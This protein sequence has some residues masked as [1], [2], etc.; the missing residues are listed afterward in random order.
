LANPQSLQNFHP[1]YWR[2]FIKLFPILQAFLLPFVNFF[3]FS[4]KKR[5]SLSFSLFPLRYH[6]RKTRKG[7]RFMKIAV[8][9]GASS[10]MGAEFA[11]HVAKKESFDA[12]WLIA[13][14]ADR[15]EA[16]AAELGVPCR[17][18]AL[19]L[20]EDT[21][22][23]RYRTLL[24]AERP[25]IGLLIN[26]SGYGK[27]GHTR[28]VP[29]AESQGMIDLN[30]RALVSMT[31]LSLPY[32]QR[33]AR[34]WQLDSLS[35]F[36]PVP[37][38]NVYAATKAFVLRYSRALNRELKSR[39]IGVTAVCPFW[40]K[41]EFFGRA[42]AEGEEP[43]VKKYIAMYEPD[44]IV[45]RAWR[46]AKRGKD[47]SRYGFKARG[48]SLLTKIVPHSLVMTIWMGQQDL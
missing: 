22:F 48:Q 13:R 23:D 38:L 32:M 1:V 14:R 37:Y 44:Q 18:L 33:G 21:S 28:D 40:T 20:T 15:L 17:V 34:I 7:S 24:E 11:R 10:G 39:G 45:G 27:F 36:Q 47:V 4:S 8:I 30:C 19:D 26:C 9:T 46:D 6:K 41:T 16:L 12:L 29:L 2:Y 35:A 43:V 3:H 42:I 25:D 31:S 5:L